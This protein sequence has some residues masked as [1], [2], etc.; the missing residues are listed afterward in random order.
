[1]YSRIAQPE[2]AG[3]SSRCFAGHLVDRSLENC[4]QAHGTRESR[5]GVKQDAVQIYRRHGN[6]WLVQITLTSKAT[7]MC[8]HGLLQTEAISRRR[9]LSGSI[10]NVARS[11]HFYRRKEITRELQGK[12]FLEFISTDSVDNLVDGVQHLPYVSIRTDALV[13]AA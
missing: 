3:T 6:E 13:S 11:R 1:M 9:N 7:M 5:V 4:A 2:L 8:L 10:A 12:D